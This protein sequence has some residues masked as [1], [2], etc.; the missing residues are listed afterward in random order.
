MP[1]NV[2]KEM[3]ALFDVILEKSEMGELPSD[4][5]VASFERL[6]R[7]FLSFAKEEWI[8][9][10]EDLVHLSVQLVRA[11]KKGQTQDAIQLVESLN[12]ARNFCHRTHNP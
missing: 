9:E 12:D 10:C 11:V 7:R 2:K 6:A 1:A 4:N 5:E 3:Q 8:E